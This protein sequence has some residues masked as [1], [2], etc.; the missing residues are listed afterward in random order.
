M[1]PVSSSRSDTDEAHQK[2]QGYIDDRPKRTHFEHTENV[3]GRW[4]GYPDN[5]LLQRLFADLPLVS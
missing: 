2:F 3:H 4:A 5:R 1:K